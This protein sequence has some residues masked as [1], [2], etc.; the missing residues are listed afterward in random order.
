MAHQETARAFDDRAQRYQHS[1]WHADYARALVTELALS[2]GD[3]VLDCGAGTG[4]ASRPAAQAVGEHGQVVAIDVSAQMLARLGQAQDGAAPIT[5]MQAD[6]TALPFAGATFEAVVCSAALLYMD[7][8]RALGEWHRVLTPDGA[9]GFSTMAA[10]QPPAAELF[11]TVAAEWGVL[12]TDRS[13]ALGTREACLDA[14]HRAGFS[15]AR[16]SHAV[17]RFTAADL[18]EAWAANERGARHELRAHLDAD[19][20]AQMRTTYEQRLGEDLEGMDHAQV[21]YATARRS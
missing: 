16:V 19:A 17:V 9:I 15:Q 20:L 18:E 13:A 10:G 5:A 7:V 6:A 1:T 11:R 14:L 21:L 2:P 4:M 8:P 3:R 12:L